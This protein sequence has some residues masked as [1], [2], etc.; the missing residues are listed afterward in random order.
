MASLV[1][2][3]HDRLTAPVAILVDDVAA[4]AV[5]EQL[6]IEAIVARP[7]LRVRTNA[8]FGLVVGLIQVGVHTQQLRADQA[9]ARAA[10]AAGIA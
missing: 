2:I 6:G 3:G 5:F 1:E 9:M 10:S 8:D 7:R 4:I